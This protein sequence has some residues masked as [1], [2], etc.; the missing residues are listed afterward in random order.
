MHI[1]EVKMARRDDG[2]RKKRILSVIIVAIFVLS[3]FGI[4]FSGFTN[5]KQALDFNN[6]VFEQDSNG[7]LTTTVNKT[8][9]KIQTNPY[10]AM[11]IPI[12]NSTMDILAG[13]QN[14]YIS[15]PVKGLYP[16]YVSLAVF[17]LAEFL[18]GRSVYALAGISDDNS[19]YSSIKLIDCRNASVEVP[20]IL[21]EESNTTT[22][23]VAD[24]NCV[25]VKAMAPAQFITVKDRLILKMAG[26][27]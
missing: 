20:V 11:Q 15:Y 14:V 3:S 16:E 13:K 7:Y 10:E 8:K 24:G 21:F 25:R 19:A 4:M 22:G 18:A 23:I 9:I 1:N 17:D 6:L 26:V 5:Q 2:T 27:N 12:D